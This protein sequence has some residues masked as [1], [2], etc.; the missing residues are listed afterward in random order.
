MN[1][2]IKNYLKA[3]VAGRWIL[4]LILA[5]IGIYEWKTTGE[6]TILVLALLLSAGLNL[7]Y[8][9]RPKPGKIGA[10]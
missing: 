7:Y 8:F 3:K 4:L 6:T 10:E 2:V 5:I 9:L 1:T